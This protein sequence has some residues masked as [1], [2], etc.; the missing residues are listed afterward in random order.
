GSGF[1]SVYVAGITLGNGGLP[2]AASLRRVHDAMGGL[3]QITMFLLL[4]LL[5]FPS[6]LIPVAGVGLGLALFL[7][8]IARPIVVALCLAP[9][10]YLPP[11]IVFIGRV[12]LRGAVPI[13]LAMIPVMSGAPGA[14]S[15]FNV[16]FFVV[17]VGSF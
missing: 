11:E 6:R 14:S 15:L 9:V 10:R 8:F 3:S 13:I 16:V 1:L 4:G 5:V 17:V 7:A 12:G 2:H